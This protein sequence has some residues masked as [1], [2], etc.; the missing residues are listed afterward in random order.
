M[1]TY[2]IDILTPPFVICIS[3]HHHHQKVDAC[4]LWPETHDQIFMADLLIPIPECKCITII[5]DHEFLLIAS[6]GLW[7]VFTSAEACL[8]AKT[9]RC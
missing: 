6:D 4:F 3:K 1:E 9:G 7:D 8:R 5:P 2:S